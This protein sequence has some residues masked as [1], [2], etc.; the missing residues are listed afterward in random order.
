MRDYDSHMYSGTETMTFIIDLMIFLGSALMVWNI[1]RYIR[2]IRMVSRKGNWDKERIEL[3]IPLVLLIGF[4]IGYIVVGVFGKPDIVMSGILFFG[5]VFVFLMI[6]MIEKVT[7]HIQTTEHLEAKLMAAEESNKAKTAFLSNMSHEIRTPMNAII[8]VSTIALKAPDLSEEARGQFLKIDSSARHLLSLIND[9]LDMSR[10]ESGQMVVRDEPMSMDDVIS[11]VSSII[12]TQCREKGLEFEY[13][14]NGR[15]DSA[16]EG[17]ACCMGDDIKVKQVLINVLGNAVKYTPAPGKVSLIVDSQNCCAGKCDGDGCHVKF[18]V[19]DTG[20]GMDEEFLPHLFDT[21]SQ[22]DVSKTNQYG[23]SGLGMAITKSLVDMM[24]GTISVESIKG[25]GTTFTVELDFM[26]LSQ[27]SAEDKAA[28][29]EESSDVSLAGRRIL[30]AEDVEINAEILCDLL[31]LNDMEADW[32]GDGQ[33]AVDK[34]R[35][36]EPGYYDAILM[37]MR[38]PVMDGVTAAR[39]I[40]GLDREDARTIPIIALT[41]NAFYKDVRECLDAGMDAHLSKP[42]DADILAETLKKMIGRSA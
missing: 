36:S 29:R 25:K 5:S 35:Q 9:I 14:V 8:G 18:T 6:R 2:F 15:E 39:L 41:A 28:K 4:L 24:G 26:P 7:V 37:D 12:E 30:F 16:G 22:E 38:M 23:G 40:R 32:A 1:W 11:Q 21:F 19:N 10:I 13:V 34:F 27:T 42:V 33:I 20:I 3:Q 31:E 17:K